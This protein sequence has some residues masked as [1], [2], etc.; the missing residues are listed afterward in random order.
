M[1][2]PGT[3]WLLGRSVLK[4]LKQT[5]LLTLFE[6]LTA[7]GLKAGGDYIYNEQRG[8]VA[9][10]NGSVIVLKDLAHQPSDP[11]YDSLGSS[12]YTGAFIDEASQVANKAKEVVGSRIRFKLDAYGLV[13]KL[14]LTC[15]PSKGW[16]Y[17]EFYRPAREG[18]LASWRAF[19]P[20]LPT[21]NPH[22]S[23]HYLESLRRL[24][25]RTLRE[26]LLLGNW[27][28]DDDPTA[29]FTHEAILDL[30]TNKVP[31]STDLFITCDAARLGRDLCLIVV[32][33]GMEA[34][35]V[36]TYERSRTTEVEAEI[37]RLRG[38]YGIRLS[39]VLVDETGVGGGIVDHLGCR[40]FVG[41]SSAIQ[42]PF[43]R[44]GYRLNYQNLRVQ[45][46]YAL[47]E[48]VR[49]GSI[50][51]PCVSPEQQEL[52]LADLA[53]IKGKDLDKDGKV[54]LVDKD[55]MKEHLGRSPDWGDVIS[56]R[57]Y[58]ELQPTEM[59]FGVFVA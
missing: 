17:A 4:T 11:N 32:W 22:L 49:Q 8:E 9:F 54:K 24:T 14:L 47:A 26:R 59:E 33:R 15:N 34:I 2:Y 31:T 56:M 3:R 29:L 43:T 52:I 55:E 27:D 45:C 51:V 37:E 41:G 21:D 46:Y 58:F 44:D 10:A 20:A 13:P 6:V 42:D 53:Q 30:F 25:D 7:W 40:G 18:N 38:T 35:H 48:A 1:R 12:E 5:T 36:T 23:P 39:N 28:Y 19:V 16:L 57:M 50:A